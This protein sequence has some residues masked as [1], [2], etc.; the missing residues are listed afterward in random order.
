[1]SEVQEEGAAAPLLASNTDEDISL[2][3]VP[4]EL[5]TEDSGDAVMTDAATERRPEARERPI[6]REFA[7]AKPFNNAKS[8][9]RIVVHCFKTPP[10]NHDD[11]DLNHN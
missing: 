7:C 6:V 10:F 2:V 9:P 4:Q 3:Q 1:M 11:R 8:F 5:A